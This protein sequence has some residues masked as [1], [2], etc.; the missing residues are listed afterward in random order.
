MLEPLYSSGANVDRW[1]LLRSPQSYT[2]T[3][4]LHDRAFRSGC[5]THGRVFRGENVIAYKGRG[6]QQRLLDD[7]V[8]WLEVIENAT[9]H[10]KRG[11]L[12]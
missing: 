4:D 6:W 7:A 3:L 1:H 10:V 11:G 2:A 5:V 8:A 12:P 9:K